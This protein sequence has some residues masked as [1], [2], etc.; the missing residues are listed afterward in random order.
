MNYQ[1]RPLAGRAYGCEMKTLKSISPIRVAPRK[2]GGNVIELV[3]LLPVVMALLTGNGCVHFNDKSEP[4]SWPK[5]ISAMDTKQFD[6]IFKNQNVNATDYR[7]GI[8]ITDLFDF[9]TGRRTA[10]GMRGSQVEIRASKDGNALA[11]GLLDGQGS[12][13]AATDLHRGLDFDL[14]SGALVVYGPFAGDHVSS[15]NLGAG[16]ERHSAKLYVSSTH[17]LLGTQSSSNVGL[18][19]YCVPMAMGG[20]DWIL[21]PGVGHEERI[22]PP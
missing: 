19:F 6:G 20:K 17:D 9:I 21:W 12:E 22:Q 14:S 11:V 3:L 7:S 15:G 13:I 2:R 10:N 16:V 4:S 18:L 8:P 5:P 1:F